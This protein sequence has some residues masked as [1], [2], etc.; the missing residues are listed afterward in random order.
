M[1]L[2]SADLVLPTIQHWEGEIAEM[3]SPLKQERALCINKM[4]SLSNHLLDF[5]GFFLCVVN[6]GLSKSGHDFHLVRIVKL[7][8]K[9]F[10]L[11]LHNLYNFC[12]RMCPHWHE[13]YLE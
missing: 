7:I 6:Q 8:V 3:S 11:N 4:P 1:P 2:V 12:G 13:T 5:Q 9:R 10:I